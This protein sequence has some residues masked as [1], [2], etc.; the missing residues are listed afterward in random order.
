MIREAKIWG[1]RWIVREDSTH[2]TSVL[3]VKSDYRCS[4][5]FH[6]TKWNCFAVI[7][8]QFEIITEDGEAQLG[9]GETFT[10]EP[11]LWHEFR[12]YEKSIVVEEM[13]VKY[14]PEDIERD[15]Q[16]G[17]IQPCAA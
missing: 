17:P 7:Q 14:D 13:Y 5:H 15:N 10:V 8:G 6:R 2:E 16:G 11:G 12:A 3:F 1:E 4:W 9:S